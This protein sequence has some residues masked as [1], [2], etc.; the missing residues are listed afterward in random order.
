MSYIFDN[1]P[2][3]S[4]SAAA[5]AAEG[6]NGLPHRPA[7]IQELAKRAEDSYVWDP[8][9]SFKD[10][11]K[12]AEKARHTAQ[13]LDQF[14]D[15]ENAFVYYATA[16]TLILQDIPKHRDYYSRLDAVQRDTLILVCVL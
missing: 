1:T 4:A 7:T 6:G 13:E 10:W 3:S 16:A 15:M 9:I 14:G 5:A 11:L 8:S 2:R 12:T